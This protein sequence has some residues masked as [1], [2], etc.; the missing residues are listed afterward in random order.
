MMS[1]SRQVPETP[2]WR[3]IPVLLLRGGSLVKGERFRRH[4]YIGDPLN[5]VSIFN[6]LRVDEIVILDIEATSLARPPNVVDAADLAAECMMPVTFGGGICRIQEIHDLLRAGIEKIVINTAAHRTPAIVE[7]AAQEF[8]SQCIVV[9][10]D[11]AAADHGGWHVWTANAS[12]NTGLG[13]VEFARRVENLGAGE[14]LLTSIDKEGT[15]T[16]YDIDLIKKVSGA[17]SIPVIACGGAGTR[18]NLPSA[19]FEGGASAAAA[20]SLFVFQKKGNGVLVNFPTRT[21]L[22]QLFSAAE[23]AHRR[24]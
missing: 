3:V 16:G 4:Q 14:I 21:E 15:M 10:I 20:A 19:V 7:E 1:E 9:S 12:E 24:D 11:V 22:R 6:Q 17:V 13:P 18:S 23:R 2:M 5:V 8:G